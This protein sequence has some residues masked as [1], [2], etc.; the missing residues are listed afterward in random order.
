MNR[1]VRWISSEVM[2]HSE[3]CSEESQLP[4]TLHP[5]GSSTKEFNESATRWFVQLASSHTSSEQPIAH[6][7]H[8]SQSY[9]T[10]NIKHGVC[11][12]LRV[13]AKAESVHTAA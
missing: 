10:V 12:V 9:H 3:T 5:S 8:V 13:A 1:G 11:E 4:L 6:D 7:A 2:L